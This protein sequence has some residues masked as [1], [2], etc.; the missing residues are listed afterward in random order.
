MGGLLARR[1]L[2]H[3]TMETYN[4]RNSAIARTSALLGALGILLTLSGCR[5][6]GDIFKAGAAVG[7]IAVV[8]VLA[9]VGGIAA[10]ITRR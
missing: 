2:L 10:L 6:V 8:I 1:V 3:R 4:H 7:V 5:L 9:I